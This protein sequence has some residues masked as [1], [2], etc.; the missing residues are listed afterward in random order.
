[1]YFRLV[2]LCIEN[3]KFNFLSSWTETLACKDQGRFKT[4]IRTSVI[5]FLQVAPQV[6]EFSKVGD[7]IGKVRVFRLNSLLVLARLGGTLH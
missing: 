3:T 7:L 1:M 2:L 6:R 5:I 4:V